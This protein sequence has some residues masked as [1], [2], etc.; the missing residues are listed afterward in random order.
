MAGTLVIDGRNAL[1]PEAIRATGLVYEG[2]GRGD[3]GGA[4]RGTGPRG[5]QEALA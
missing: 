4:P 1:D 3:R 5:S 2:V